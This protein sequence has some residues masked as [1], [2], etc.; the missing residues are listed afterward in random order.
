MILQRAIRIMERSLG[1]L[2]RLYLIIG[3]ALNAALQRANLKKYSE[4]AKNSLRKEGAKGEGE[5]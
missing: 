2:L 5:S 1:Q 4:K 3:Y